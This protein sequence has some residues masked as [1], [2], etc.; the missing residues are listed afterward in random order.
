M[1]RHLPIPFL[2]LSLFGAFTASAAEPRQATGTFEGKNWTFEAVGALAFPG[3]VG[4]DDE[5]GIRVVVSN[6]GFKTEYFERVWDRDHV[7]ET[8]FKDEETLV[9]TFQFAK[10]GEYKGMTYYFGSGDGCGFCYDGAV[11][12]TVKVEKGR[13]AGKVA[14][15]GKEGDNSFDI[16]FDVPVL[17]T[18]YGKALPAGFGEPGKAYVAYHQ[19]LEGDSPQAL[20]S[21]LTADE[22]A[23]LAKDGDSVLSSRRQ[24]HPTKAYKITKGW[25]KGD[26][27]LLLVEGEDSYMGVET[28][29]HL[30][31]EKGG[32][33]VE[34]EIMQ[35]RIGE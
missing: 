26:R 30:V 27:A 18:D 20:A 6:A 14:V 22:A 7:I 29:V 21:L 25:T 28:E 2:L 5:P 13:I 19:A 23:K 8:F 16:S 24:N 3:E 33:K 11:K 34:D 1:R 32:W 4:F 10:N 35:V 12:S 9:V 31:L 17:G 15:K